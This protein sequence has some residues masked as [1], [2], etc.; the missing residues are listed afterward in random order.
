MELIM[1]WLKACPQCRG[2]L[3]EKKDHYGWYIACLQ[4]GYQLSGDEE[5]VALE[6]YSGRNNPRLP[7]FKEPDK[8]DSSIEVGAYR[9]RKWRDSQRKRR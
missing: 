5:E 4:C 7:K 3:Y 2:D 6:A 9:H 1:F 8:I